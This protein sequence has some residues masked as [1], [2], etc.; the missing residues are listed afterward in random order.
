MDIH[1]FVDLDARCRDAVARVR[2]RRALG[3]EGGQ[4]F[5]HALVVVA[6]LGLEEGPRTRDVRRRH[7]RAAEVG[8]AAIR[9]AAS[10]IRRGRIDHRAGRQQTEERRAVRETR[11]QIG[12]GGRAHADRAGDAGRRRHRARIARVAGRHHCGDVSRAQ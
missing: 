4:H 3:L 12:V 8:E 6:L 9:A 2:D 10:V 5:G 1:R 11:H 7:R